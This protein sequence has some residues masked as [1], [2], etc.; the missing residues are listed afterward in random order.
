MLR[1]RA[2]A[3]TRGSRLKIHL[4]SVKDMQTQQLD[5][6][7]FIGDR[8]KNKY[9]KYIVCAIYWKFGCNVGLQTSEERGR[10][11]TFK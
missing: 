1:Y 6:N 11:Q 3:N 9:L 10:W 8:A 2:Q 7:I 5:K 4:W